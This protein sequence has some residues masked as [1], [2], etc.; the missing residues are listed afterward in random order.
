MS[1]DAAT[2]EVIDTSKPRVQELC[3]K[4]FKLLEAEVMKKSDPASF[5]DVLGALAILPVFIIDTRIKPE[6][7]SEKARVFEAV[8]NTSD[9]WFKACGDVEP[10]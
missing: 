2:L 8:K 3:T 1:D 7:V 10:S 6:C 9:M 5:E 4:V